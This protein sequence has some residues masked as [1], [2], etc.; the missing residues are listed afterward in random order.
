MPQDSSTTNDPLSGLLGA[1][2]GGHPAVQAHM[3]N[4]GQSLDQVL[5]SLSNSANT[6]RG[7]SP[8]RGSFA[9]I[10]GTTMGGP[11]QSGN[12]PTT[13]QGGDLMSAL[14]GGLLGGGAQGGAPMQNAAAG[15]GDPM[16]A[17][18]GS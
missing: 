12:V 11:S 5:G 15:G 8:T 17:L 4:T 1:L 2:I 6:T 7:T 10:L 9:D 16:S 18:L 3:Q 13:D 14:L